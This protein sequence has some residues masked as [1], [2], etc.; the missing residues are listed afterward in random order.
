MAIVPHKYGHVKIENDKDILIITTKDKNFFKRTL[1]I[2]LIDKVDVWVKEKHIVLPAGSK[3]HLAGNFIVFDVGDM[4]IGLDQY[5]LKDKTDY[6]F[7][8]HAQY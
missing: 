8:H 2:P 4:F 5:R 7:P 1:I 3:G 6:I